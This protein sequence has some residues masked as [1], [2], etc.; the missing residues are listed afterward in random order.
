MLAESAVAILAG[1]LLGAIPFAYFAGR[2]FKKVDIRLAGGGNVGATN[3]MR[4]VGTAAGIGVL[5]AD[6]AKGAAA[7]LLA[8]ALGVPEIVVF[9]A[10]FA[11]VVGH[12]WSVFL[13]F[14]GGKGGA[15][16]IGVLWGLIPPVASAIM[17]GIMLLAAFATSNLRLS[18]GVGFFCLPFMLWGFGAQVSLIVYSIALP[19]FSGLRALPSIIKG[20]RNPEE[21]KNFFID[22]DHKPWQKKK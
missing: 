19:L 11:A 8:K 20:A 13:K 1:Y 18:L 16:S 7:V 12:N 6:I 14:G 9:I 2:L 17:F 22:K 4:E 21:R 10:G 15:A 5:A 3:V